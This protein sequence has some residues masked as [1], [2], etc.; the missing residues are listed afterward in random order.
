MK[1]FLARALV[2]LLALLPVVAAAQTFP[3]VP[4]GTVIGRTAVGTGPSQ[5]IPIT[6]LIS[7]MLNPL[8]VTSV[9]TASVIYRGATSG[10]VTVSAPAVAGTR[11]I[12]LPTASGTMAVSATSPVALNATT[13][14]ISCTTCV[15]GSG[16]PTTGDLTTYNSTTGLAIVGAGYKPSQIPGLIPATATV[17]ISNATPGIITWASH[18]R[19]VGDTIFFCNSGG[20]LPTGLTACTP[21]GGTVS[22]NTYKSNPTLYYVCGGSTLLGGSFAVATSMANAKAGTCVNTS[23]NG[24]GTHTAFANAMACAGCV[25]EMIWDTREIASALAAVDSSAGQTVNSIT[26][27]AG[28]WEV[29]GSTGIIK[30]NAGTPVM[31]HLHSSIVY[32]F[33]TIATSP[34]NGT[35]AAHVN[36]NDPNGWIFTNNPEQVI[37]T[38]STTV[39]QVATSNFTPTTANTAGLY[40]S[41]KARRIH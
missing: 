39:N 37:M 2:A 17:T 34:Y 19:V 3:T 13:G 40:G 35:T 29:W 21:A 4:S 5:A 31:N 27:S 16:T 10:T 33:S 22:A 9:N 24:S 11:T 20:A 26:L 38:G 41:I 15:T 8:T 1:Q 7:T 23:S 14:D 30:I 25:G 6:T 18:G 12:T 28:I 32:G 36:S